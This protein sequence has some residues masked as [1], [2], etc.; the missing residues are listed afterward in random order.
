MPWSIYLAFK[1]LFPPGKHFPA[2]A[3]VSIIGVAIGVCSLL[4]VQTVMN[5]Y[6]REHRE[7]I[8]RMYG[9]VVVTDSHGGAIANHKALMATLEK[10]PGVVAASPFA[11]GQVMVRHGDIPALPFVRG[12]DLDKEDNVVPVKKFLT[13][14]EPDALDDDRVIVGSELARMLNLRVRVKTGDNGELVREL[15]PGQTIEVYSPTMLDAL[16]DDEVPMPVELEVCGLFESGYRPADE[17][18]II[19]SLRRM[20]ELYNLGKNVQGIRLRVEDP[21]AVEKI[22]PAI[23]RVLPMK[24]RATPWIYV[25]WNFLQAVQFEKTLLFF[26]MFIITLVASFSIASTLFSAVVKR[27]REIGI[28]G[29]L[30]ARPRQI[31][32]IFASQGVAVGAIGYGIGCVL[33]FVIIAARDE[34]VS[35]INSIFGSGD[36]IQTQYLFSQIPVHYNGN[37]FLVAAIFTILTTTV[38][39]LIPAIWAARRKPSEA[40]R[41]A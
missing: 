34:I 24:L 29:A 10:V 6:G 15:V 38:A 19:V 20:Q 7:N 25:N 26:L 40:M 41:E 32:V 35:F 9:H 21:E 4:V 1:Q 30:G 3:L 23:C 33:T 2:F 14:G 17:N 5:G 28:L 18:T 8:Q 22:I 12:I 11:E 27:S 36:M 31:L 16:K 39:G 37:D 13:V